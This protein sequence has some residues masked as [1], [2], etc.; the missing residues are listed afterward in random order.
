MCQVEIEKV[1][2]PFSFRSYWINPIW[3]EYKKHHV[4]I[5]ACN[6]YHRYMYNIT[7]IWWVASY[8][9]TV[10]NQEGMSPT[11]VYKYN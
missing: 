5:E 3:Y 1:L 10:L 7:D 8:L 11:S 6:E 9:D 4:M 2:F